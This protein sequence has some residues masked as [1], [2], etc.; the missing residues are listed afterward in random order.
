M[1]VSDE[2][3][4]I[5]QRKMA[6]THITKILIEIFD[7]MVTKKHDHISRELINSNRQIFSSIRNPWDW[8][9]S[10]WTYGVEVGG[11]LKDR[12]IK[13]DPKFQM[14]Y[15]DANDVNSFRNWLKFIHDYENSHLLGEGYKS[16]NIAKFC[17]FMS[18]RY[19]RHCCL[20][21]SKMYV[22]NEEELN[23][24]QSIKTSQQ[25]SDFD[26]N[27][28]FI[29][30]FIRQEELEFSLI[31]GISKIRSLN[32]NEIDYITQ[33]EKTNKSERPLLISEYYDEDSIEI[34]RRRDSLIVEKFGYNPPNA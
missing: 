14:F 3:I 10:L 12:L 21:D 26:K 20:S 2:L 25:V 16:S 6:C 7:G 8:Y 31:S 23:K 9:L 28:C 19:L 15:Q 18:F 4:F 13:A 5:Q 32:Q 1:F 34:I 29:D 24:L 17:G 11:G 33:I 30:Y 27:E 22:L